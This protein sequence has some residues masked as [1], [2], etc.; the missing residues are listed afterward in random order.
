MSIY[1]LN[2]RGKFKM[3]TVLILLRQMVIMFIL[4]G[5]GYLMFH[6]KKISNEGSKSLGNILI[7]ISL[8]CVIIKSFL[9]ERSTEAT[10][11]LGLSALAAAVILACSILISRLFFK[12]DAIAGFASAFSNPG[13]FGIPIIV[14]C[15]SDGAVFYIASF[16]AFLNFLQWTYGVSI[17]QGKSASLTFKRVITAP[18]MIAIIIGLFFYFTGFQMPQILLQC[19]TFLSQ[20]NTPL[21]M[22]TIGIYLAQTNVAKMFCQKVLYGISAVRLIIIPLVSLLLL[23]LLPNTYADLKM[24]VLIAS[25]CPVGSNVAVYAHLHQKD[26]PY[27]VETVVISTI[28]SLITIPLLTALASLLWKL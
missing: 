3:S 18:F 28:L 16:I 23:S 13:F 25:A 11:G 6:F 14:A 20:L 5:V 4:M 1:F 27:A 15:V 8:P 2:L 10:I 24:A 17:L 7:F 21:A 19:V 9:V 22:F 26:Y 12:K